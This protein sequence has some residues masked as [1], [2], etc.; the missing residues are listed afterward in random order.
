MG[1]ISERIDKLKREAAALSSGKML[2]GT[3][4]NC[5]PEIE[6]QFWKNVLGIWSAC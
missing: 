2:T 5:P 1:D 3:A 6:E 4:S